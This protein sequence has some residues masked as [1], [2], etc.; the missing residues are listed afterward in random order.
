VASTGYRLSRWETERDVHEMATRVRAGTASRCVR[1]YAGYEE[2]SAILTRREVAQ[3]GTSLVLAFGDR[4]TVAYD[5]A[6]AP[7]SL[8]AFVLGTQ[9]RASLTTL[10]GCQRGVQ[11]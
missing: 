9:T 3:A 7:V 11:V 5:E 6:E 10:S 1:R 8:G 4:V 2:Q